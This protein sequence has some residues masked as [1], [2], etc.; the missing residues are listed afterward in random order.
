MTEIKKFSKEF[1][2]AIR[3]IFSDSTGALSSKRVFGG[4]GFVWALTLASAN[5]PFDMVMGI[6]SISAAMLGTDAITDIWKK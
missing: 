5:Y 1:L 6:V 2:L 3:E 4:L